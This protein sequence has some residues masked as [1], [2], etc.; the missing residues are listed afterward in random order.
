[1]QDP[2]AAAL[3][4]P[5][6]RGVAAG[7]GAGA[8]NHSCAPSRQD[9]GGLRTPGGGGGHDDHGQE[10]RPQVRFH[11]RAV[12][13]QP[14]AAP[15]AAPA[16]QECLASPPPPARPPAA[17]SAHHPG[18]IPSLCACPP[19]PCLSRHLP[20]QTRSVLIN[21]WFSTTRISLCLPWGVGWR[22][23]GQ[24]VPTSLLRQLGMRGL[25]EGIRGAL[26]LPPPQQ[27]KN[28]V[29]VKAE[30]NLVE[31]GR[32]ERGVRRDPPPQFHPCRLGDGA[33]A[34]NE[35]GAP[36]PLS[37]SFCPQGSGGR[38]GSGAPRPKGLS[39]QERLRRA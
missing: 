22:A 21:Y 3:E 25:P 15:R 10:A 38:W 4:R 11:L 30:G 12:A 19:L 31:L 18:T 8:D 7:G 35:G 34:L 39:G 36:G 29:S 23:A 16:R 1:M 32:E 17:S 6:S 33:S 5:S 2:Q 27:R 9:A 20:T 14:P 24:G 37:A 28:R 13:L 26:I